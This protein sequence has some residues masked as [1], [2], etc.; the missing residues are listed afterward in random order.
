MRLTFLGTRAYIDAAKRGH[1]R[2]SAALVE[3]PGP[4]GSGAAARVMLDCGLDW[5]A[6]VHRLRPDAIVLTHAHP[7]HAFGLQDGAPCPVH[8]TE[9]A[10]ATI[11]EFPIAARHL[12]P[13]ATEVEV[14][15]LRLTAFPVAHS[16]RCPAVALR[17][18]A[19]G[20]RVLYAPDVAH[21][22][23]RDRVLDG[24][25]V[26]IGDGSSLERSLVRKAGDTLLGHAP[27]RQQLTWCGKAGVP[28]AL[29]THC[30][31]EVVARDARPAAR[32]LRTLA[33]ERGLAARFAHDGLRVEADA[34]P[35]EGG[36]PPGDPGRG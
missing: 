31:P 19:P 3:V 33:A 14:A 22:P 20:G 15:G 9:A 25:R 13:E 35:A 5:R 30:G 2:H 8:A 32:R 17:L 36:R 34:E 16:T 4:R 11:A 23:E 12:L 21:I 10:W 27:V 18:E 6:R 7:D 26:Y 24:V 29:F 1:R 28:R